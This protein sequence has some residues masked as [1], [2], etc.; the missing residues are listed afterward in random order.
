MA[1]LYTNPAISGA[2]VASSLKISLPTANSLIEDFTRL[3]ILK[4]VTGSKRNR[5]FVFSDY[6]NLFQSKK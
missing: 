5:L 4:E 2:V 1:V 3:G 6:M